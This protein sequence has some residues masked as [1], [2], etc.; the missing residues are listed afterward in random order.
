MFELNG[1]KWLNTSGSYYRTL[2]LPC[3][4]GMTDMGVIQDHA[5]EGGD[6]GVNYTKIKI[7]CNAS[8]IHKSNWASDAW[9]SCQCIEFHRCHVMPTIFRVEG[10]FQGF[11]K[12]TGFFFFSLKAGFSIRSDI[13]GKNKI[14]KFLL[15]LYTVVV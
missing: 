1:F 10:K 11:E 2:R 6:A 14:M 12:Y 13:F 15:Y 5:Y 4:M 9:I 3:T 8:P 7:H